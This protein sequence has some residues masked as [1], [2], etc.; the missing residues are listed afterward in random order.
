MAIIK[1]IPKGSPLSA[2]EMDANLTI[3]ENVSSS[4]NILYTTTDVLN[5]SASTLSNSLTSL[6]SSVSSLSTL[7]GQLSG[8]FTGSVLISGSLRFDNISTDAVASEVLVYNSS[9]KTIGKTTSI[10][11]GPAGSD[12]SSLMVESK[13]RGQNI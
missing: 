4:V 6:S 9:T 2:A 10:A 11:T 5:T 1:R 13:L 12:G 7:S 8:Q 3:L